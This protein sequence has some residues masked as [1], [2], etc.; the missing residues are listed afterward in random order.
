MVTID[1]RQKIQLNKGE[2]YISYTALAK[3]GCRIERFK[4]KMYQTKQPTDKQIENAVRD[5]R[6]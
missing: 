5:Q 6:K 2:W 1:V 3:C 4:I